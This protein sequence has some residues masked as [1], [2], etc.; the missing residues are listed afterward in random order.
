[1]LASEGSQRGA[2]LLVVHGGLVAVSGEHLDIGLDLREVALVLLQDALHLVP[3]A[4]D[5]HQ[6]RVVSP[7]LWP[8][9][10]RLEAF[11]LQAQ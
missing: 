7:T 6:L 9:H 3:L 8:T 1:M 5:P 10:A 4:Q 11:A 2:H